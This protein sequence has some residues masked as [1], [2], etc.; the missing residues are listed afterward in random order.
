MRIRAGDVISLWHNT[1]FK[2]QIKRKFQD[3]NFGERESWSV[4]LLMRRT[5]ILDESNLLYTLSSVVPQIG[6]VRETFFA[7][8]L[9][10]AGHH[11]EYA[12]YK[13]GD[14]RIDN[15]YIIEV[16]GADKG[17]GQIESIEHS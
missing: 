7:N 2:T 9:L 8:Q 10:S 14:F 17:Y 4:R 16:G 1:N 13:S 3:A 5:A 15:H 12:G 11:L 6:T